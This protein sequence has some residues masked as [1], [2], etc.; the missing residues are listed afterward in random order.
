MESVV[1]L[2]LLTP[3]KRKKAKDE[4]RRAEGVD[5]AKLSDLRKEHKLKEVDSSV[6]AF[7]KDN[8]KT[9]DIVKSLL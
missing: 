1:K 2:S 6:P 4:K 3:E 9:K 8:K 7:W 5:A